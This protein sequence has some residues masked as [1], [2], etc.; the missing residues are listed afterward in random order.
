[1]REARDVADGEAVR[2]DGAV[3][4][5]ALADHRNVADVGAAVQRRIRRFHRAADGMHVLRQHAVG[6]E[7][8]VLR[9]IEPRD[10][11]IHDLA[12][13]RERRCCVER[14]AVRRARR[15]DLHLVRRRVRTIDRTSDIVEQ[16]FILKRAHD[17]VRVFDFH[18]AR[19][20]F[21]LRGLRCDVLHVP[22]AVVAPHERGLRS[23]HTDRVDGRRR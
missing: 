16:K 22:R 15:R 14:R 12:L 10:V 8:D 5:L 4:D 3:R 6:D 17:C 23:V 20:A 13:T 2:V 7:R 9:G 18:L 19:E 11:G 21:A 1:M